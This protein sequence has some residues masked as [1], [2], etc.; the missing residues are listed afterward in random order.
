MSRIWPYVLVALLGAV[1]AQTGITAKLGA[2]PWW[3]AQVVWIGGALGLGLAALLDISGRAGRFS[4]MA[5]MAAGLASW[6]VAA[7][8]KSRFAASFAEDQLAG[9]FW[10]YGWIAA[11]G[12]ITAA[13]VLGLRSVSRA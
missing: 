1:A 4:A 6:A 13:L 3:A 10:H 12:W 9:V 7:W 2:H 11:A 8:G 5:A